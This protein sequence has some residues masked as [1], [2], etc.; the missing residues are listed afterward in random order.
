MNNIN[1]D[2]TYSRKANTADTIYAFHNFADEYDYYIVQSTCSYYPDAYKRWK[3]NDGYYYAAGAASYFEYRHTLTMDDSYFNLF[4]NAPR[5]VNRKSTVTDG[6]EHNTSSTSGQS[7]GVKVNAS[8]STSLADGLSASISTELSHERNTSKTSGASYS[9]SASWETEEWALYNQCDSNAAQWHAS[10][11]DDTPNFYAE[12]DGIDARTRNNAFDCE[13]MWQVKDP[14]Q[15]ATMKITLRD[16]Q[17]MCRGNGRVLYE[18]NHSYKTIRY[19]KLAQPPHVVLT[20]ENGLTFDKN[21]KTNMVFKF[22]CNHDWTIYSTADWIRISPEQKTGHNTGPSEK[23][24]FWE[25]DAFDTG[26]DTSLHTREGLLIVQDNV[27][28]QVQ[29]LHVTQ[30]NK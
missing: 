7:T 15:T 8:V 21:A 5:N 9:H 27:T 16:R 13:W 11:D 23:S 18:R 1:H 3:E 25:L 30:S 14:T 19:V 10:Y 29:S 24:I 2:W 17:L 12:Y 4:T 6:S 20:S 28:K 22:L 26:S